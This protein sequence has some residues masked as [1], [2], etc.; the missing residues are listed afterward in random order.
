MLRCGVSIFSGQQESEEENK[1]KRESLKSSEE[2]ERGQ[3][4]I[5]KEDA[6]GIF[7]SAHI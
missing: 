3:I 6:K 1:S 5:S 2:R 7:A 4:F